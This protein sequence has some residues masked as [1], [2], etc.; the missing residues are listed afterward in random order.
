MSEILANIVVDQTN[1]NFSPNNNNLNVTP[2]AIQLNIFTGAAPVAGGPNTSVQYS[3]SGVLE[4]SSDFVF[5][6]SNSTVIANLLEVT[7]EA[8]LG[9]PS[10][11]IISGGVN[12]YVLQTD[13]TGNLSWTAQ[14]GGGGNGSPGGSNTQIQYN[15]G[16]VFGGS[17]GFTFNKV[18]NAV[19]IPGNL[20]V[21]GG[22]A[23]TLTTA[24]QPNITSVGTLG[25]LVVTNNINAASLTTGLIT[26]NGNLNSNGTVTAFFFNGNGNPLFGL[27]GSNVIGTVANAT[28]ATSATTAGTVTTAAQPNITSLGTLVDLSISGTTSIFEAIENVNLIGAQTGTYNYDVLSGAIQ[29]STANATANLTLNFRGNATST[30][31][32]VLGNG[33]STTVTYLMTTGITGYTISNVQIDSSAQTIKW[34]NGV[35]P[36]INGNSTTA[37]TFTLVKT[38]T[39]PTYTVL[40]NASRY[41]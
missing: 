14:S 23:G 7:S 33:K 9:S 38:S 15:D 39:A 27:N 11:V 37:Y 28:F 16:G 20:S 17:V 5:D 8:N 29:Y 1:I 24:A 19:A 13:G 41:A 26:L 40:G 30:L 2:E 18:S 4:G 31:D 32:S 34:V 25:N 35:I 6:I 22:I 10:N 21:T 3:N 36:P 12:G